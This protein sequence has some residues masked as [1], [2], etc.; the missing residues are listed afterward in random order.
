L[1]GRE[2]DVAIPW[3]EIEKIGEDVLLVRTEAQVKRQ[4]KKWPW[5]K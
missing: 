4:S 5:M 1:L 3:K 2:E